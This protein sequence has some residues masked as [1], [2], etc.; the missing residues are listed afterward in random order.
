[1]NEQPK[2]KKAGKRWKR[3]LRRIIITLLILAILGLGGWYAVDRLRAEYTVTYDTYTATIGSISNTLSFS[4]SLALVDSKTYS[5][6]SDTTVRTVYV[7]EGDTVTKGAK[8]MRL[9]DGTT[10]TADFD[11]KVNQVYVAADDEVSSGT[12]LVQI[13]DFSHMKVSMRVDEY[14]IADVSVGTACT[15]T[16]TATEKTFESTISSINYISASSG[17]VAYYTAVAYVD[18]NEDGIYPGMQVTVSIPKEAA[19]NVVILKEDA[20]SF[21]ASNSAYVY[22]KG[23]DGEMTT[24]DVEVGVSNGKY[25]EIKSGVSDGDTVYAVAE[26]T[27]TTS[28]LSSMLSGLFGG[29]QFTPQMGGGGNMDF[30]N[31]DFSNSDF[32]P[33]NGDSNSGGGFGGGNGGGPGGG[34]PSGN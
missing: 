5:A 31:V 12:S 30:S 23:E 6:S 24:V 2:K 16:A 19:E 27:T 28:G 21:T 9:A 15:V 3:V 7:A 1:M 13:A 25:V 11:G 4:G 34:G 29:S 33:S 18:V 14:D 22:M 26:T 8:L 10:L 17:N 20:L 32:S